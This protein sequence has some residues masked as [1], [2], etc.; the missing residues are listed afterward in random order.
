LQDPEDRYAQLDGNLW[1]LVWSDEFSDGIITTDK[2]TFE[3]GGGFG[4]DQQYRNEP[5]VVGS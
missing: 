5:F 3:V 2:W 4:E 1:K